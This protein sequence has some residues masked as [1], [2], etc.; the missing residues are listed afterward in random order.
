[1]QYVLR[2]QVPSAKATAYR[3]W[4]LENDQALRDHAAEGW[5]YLGTWFTVRGFGE[6]AAESRWDLTGYEALG[7]GFGDEIAQRL[8]GEWFDMIDADAGMDATL[9]KSASEVDIFN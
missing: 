4:L 9:L 7:S 6:Y 2:Y 8:L 1:M 5:H 3:S